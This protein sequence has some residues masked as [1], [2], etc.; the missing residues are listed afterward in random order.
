MKNINLKKVSEEITHYVYYI[1]MD[2][3][4]RIGTF[5]RFICYFEFMFNIYYHHMF[6]II[7]LGICNP[8]Q[9]ALSILGYYYHKKTEENKKHII[10]LTK[11]LQE[12]LDEIIE[13][14]LEEM[15]NNND[16]KLNYM[17]KEELDNILKNENNNDN[18]EN[19][20]KRG[21]S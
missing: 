4:H 19:N 20:E 15:I 17:I 10:M 7:L 12:K 16:D 13:I 11:E 18:E 3:L 5:F 1:T 2:R 6:G 21:N 8:I 14:E 9:I